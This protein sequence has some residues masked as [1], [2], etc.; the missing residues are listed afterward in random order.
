MA[1][2]NATNQR[3]AREQ[4]HG[5]RVYS[6]N[7]ATC[8]STAGATCTV[9][10]QDNIT[11]NT[12][13]VTMKDYDGD[14][15]AG[16]EDSNGDGRPDVHI[17]RGS[18]TANMRFF[19][20]VD[21]NRMPLRRVMIDWQDGTGS[22]GANPEQNIDNEHRFGLY[23]NKK[24]YCGTDSPSTPTVGLCEGLQP[25]GVTY[26]PTP[27]TCSSNS[28]CPIELQANR[29]GVAANQLQHCITPQELTSP[30]YADTLY[31][32]E[33]F[34]N[35]SPRACDAG[36]YFEFIRTYTCDPVAM[37]N[38]ANLYTLGSLQ[39]G[40]VIPPADVQRIS[41]LVNGDAAAPVCIFRPRVQILDNWGFCNG[42]A[43]NGQY[44]TYYSAF[45]QGIITI[46][47]CDSNASANSWTQYRGSIVVIP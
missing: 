30:P 39:N 35:A 21:D 44:T 42:T 16:D 10:D 32:V 11:I 41:G 38:S 33:R 12:L 7:P 24:T 4:L 3:G 19:A 14:G 23:K 34:G 1:L 9:G 46:N 40:S 13:N 17:A 36:R 8:F 43:P 29:V 27:L 37:A 28:D 47:Q 6:L 22:V 26:G 25:D 5:P 31:A 45:P 20:I 18:F 15:R 2:T